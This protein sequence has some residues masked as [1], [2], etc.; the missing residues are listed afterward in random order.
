MSKSEKSGYLKIEDGVV[1]GYK[2]IESTVVGGYKKIED[3]FVDKLLTH[4]GESVEDAK[5]RMK[6]EQQ[7]REEA[8]KAETEKRAAEQQARM[9]RINGK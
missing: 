8:A 6:A 1:K 4:E 2:K 9:N 5:A 7:A 3:A